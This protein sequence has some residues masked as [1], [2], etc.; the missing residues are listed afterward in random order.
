[1]SHFQVTVALPACFSGDAKRLYDALEIRLEPFNVEPFNES[2]T[3][4]ENMARWDW[5]VVGGHWGGT[6][7]LREPISYE[8]I[9]TEESAFGMTPDA[10]LPLATDCARVGDIAAESIGT[11]F[12]YVDAAGKWHGRGTMGWFGDNDAD[13]SEAAKAAWRKQYIDWITSLDKRTWL[14]NVDCHV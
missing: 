5:W 11:P 1:M 4:D 2:T 3:E 10:R 13:P 6:W 9:A 12:A 8:T 7:R 14:I